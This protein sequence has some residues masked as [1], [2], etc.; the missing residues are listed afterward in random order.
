MSS[1]VVRDKFNN[2]IEVDSTGANQ[3]LCYSSSANS[4]TPSP[5]PASGQTQFYLNG[6]P[7]LL[8]MRTVNYP[9]TLEDLTGA[10]VLLPIAAAQVRDV[11]RGCVFSLTSSK[12]T[13]S[14]GHPITCQ[15]VLIGSC[16][17]KPVAAVQLRAEGEVVHLSFRL[18]TAV[19]DLH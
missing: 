3:Y 13:V 10:C 8:L 4:S 12:W 2:A 5:L 9:V 14:I 19:P 16:V 15:R 7:S 1:A 6:Q 17:L 11:L 18:L